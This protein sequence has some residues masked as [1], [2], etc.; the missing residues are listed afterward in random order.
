VPL[1]QAHHGPA[2]IAWKGLETLAARVLIVW[3]YNNT[4]KSLF[5]AVLSYALSNISVA[6][7]PYA[8]S[9][10]DPG[11]TGVLTVVVAGTVA[12]LWGARTLA[13]SGRAS[14]GQGSSAAS[15]ELEQGYAGQYQADAAR[16]VRPGPAGRRNRD[17]AD[18]IAPWKRRC[19]S[20]TASARSGTGPSTG[21]P[22][23]TSRI[24]RV[25]TGGGGTPSSASQPASCSD[26]LT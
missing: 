11:F 7:F 21:T 3:L 10:Y 22:G 6:L 18:Q 19:R 26:E 20:W 5:A 23:T 14:S 4:G 12:F 13:D 1:I 9:H 24:G 2:W 8:G 25:R 15:G 16:R 17:L